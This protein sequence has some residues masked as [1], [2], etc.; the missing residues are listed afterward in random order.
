MNGLMWAGFALAVF[1]APAMA[2]DMPLKARPAPLMAPAWS[3]TGFYIGINGG[4]SVGNDSSTAS[5]TDTPVPVLELNETFGR[6]LAA[7]V[8]GGPV[9]YNWQG[10]PPSGIGVEGGS[11]WSGR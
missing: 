10:A 11:D 2:A 6:S 5:F 8:F 1:F 7:A 9:G 4:G 3:W